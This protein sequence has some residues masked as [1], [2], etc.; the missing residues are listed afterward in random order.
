[1]TDRPAKK[2]STMGTEF[3][4]SNESRQNVTLDQVKAL[5][6]GFNKR[7]RTYTAQTA[8]SKLSRFSTSM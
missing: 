2:R 3:S 7:A 4:G 1:M 5:Y 6:S 8:A